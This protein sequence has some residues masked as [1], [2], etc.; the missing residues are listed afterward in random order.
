MTD[1]ITV[2]LSKLAPWSGNVR[3]TGVHDGIDE[4]A[5]S[6]AAHGLLQ[7]L[8]VREGKRGKYQV[9][10]G[11]RR[12]LA[13]QALAKN[14]TIA[15]D[16]PVACILATDTID[17]TELSLAENVVRAPMHPA[18]QFEAFRSLI[19][20]GASIADV[21][22]RFG[23]TEVTVTRRMKLGRLSPVILEAY[24]NGDIDLEEAQAFAI[25]DDQEAQERVL[26]SLSSWNRQPHI[27]RRALTEHEVETSDKR[28]RF[29]G[30]D[31]YREAGGVIRQD[32]FSES[33]T[34]YI[35]DVALLD[36]LVAEK[37]KAVAAEVAAEGWHWVETV[38]EIAYGAL[39][40]FSR[41][42]PDHV[43]LPDD[44]QAELDALSQEYD[45]LVDS[46]DDNAERLAEIEARMDALTAKTEVWSA[47]ALAVAGVLVTLGY[48]G[49]VRVERGLVRKIDLPKASKTQPEVQDENVDETE[50]HGG[51]LSPRLVEELTAEKS[52]AIGAELMAQPD[53]ALAAVVHALVLDAFYRG[54]MSESCLKLSARSAHLSSAIAKP[55]G[56]KG[57]SA[58]EQERE[59]IGDH[60]PGN[61]DDLWDWL[62]ARSREELLDLLA[63]IAATSVDAVQRK[64]DRSDSSRLSHAQALAR[65]LQLD[66]GSWFKPTAENYFARV[67]RAQIIQAID[68]AH[69][70]HAPALE[71]LK[72]SELAVRAEQLLAGTAWLPGP[73]RI[74][75]NDHTPANDATDALAAE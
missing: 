50:T 48:D 21:A 24:R 33:D 10:A 35:V 5:A 11:Q 61:P 26:Q 39:S 36:R 66:M 44:E 2:P 27:I 37:L 6:I 13:L 22:A 9:V 1:T 40:D 75:I 4:L 30:I 38:P 17:A 23:V 56:C 51:G 65:A 43:D 52:A 74:A 34:G 25:T 49:D 64:L 59:R 69:G 53:I 45:S 29:V 46:D 71:K 32:L 18:D 16:Y 73:M 72:K 58:I 42:F 67:S 7:S 68:E 63:V 70:S 55:E 19:D 31:A 47:D 8:V 20:D 15:K 3:R 12:Y 62:L 41:R 57:L 14:G 60:L 28:V 54:H